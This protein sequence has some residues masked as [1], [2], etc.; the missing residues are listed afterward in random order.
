MEFDVDVVVI[1][2][3]I[4]SWLQNLHF[5]IWSFPRQNTSGSDVILHAEH[6]RSDGMNMYIFIFLLTFIYLKFSNTGK[7]T[8]V[9]DQIFKVPRRSVKSMIL[10]TSEIRRT[11]HYHQVSFDHFQWSKANWTQF[12]I[13]YLIFLL[14]WIY[15]VNF[16]LLFIRQCTWQPQLLRPFQQQLPIIGGNVEFF[17]RL[18]LLFSRNCPLNDS[19]EIQ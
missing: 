13:H 12:K 11:I 14:T 19:S 7:Y 1:L 3:V 10:F 17:L 4:F 6:L 15:F 16:Y 8:S 5:I 2:A 9:I 18:T